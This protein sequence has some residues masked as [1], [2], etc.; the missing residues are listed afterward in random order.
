MSG[1]GDDFELERLRELVGASEV[2]Y[3]AARRDRAEA[4]RVAREAAAEA[5]TLHGE[6]IELRVEVDR[7]RQEQDTLVRERDDAL[8]EARDAAAA[9]QNAAIEVDRLQREVE[10]LNTQL[11]RALEDRELL[12]QRAAMRPAR[13][14]YDQLMRRWSAVVAPR[15]ARFARRS[16]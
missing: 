11:T 9:A 3:E 10:G 16:R 13:R 8:R 15:L 7:T 5:G 2:S 14:L 6:I 4:E 1:D 12:L